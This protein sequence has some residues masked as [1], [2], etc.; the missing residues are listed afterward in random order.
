MREDSDVHVESVQKPLRSTSEASDEDLVSACRS[1]DAQ[2]WDQLVR[3]YQRLIYTVPLR[4]GLSEEDAGDVF[5]QTC[6]RLCEHLDALRDPSRLD[7]WLVSTSRRLSLDAL[8]GRRRGQMAAAASPLAHA[9]HEDAV[10]NGL[11]VLEEQQRIRRAVMRLAPRCRALVYHLFYDPAEP[12]YAEIAAAL[13]MP[14]GSIGP[15][16]ARC[17]AKLKALLDES[18]R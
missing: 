5:Q 2:A 11:E 3:R 10:E 8:N 14:K 1:G 16:R 4:F 7:A 6:L 17:F 9:A 15:V 18:H 13:G 12:S